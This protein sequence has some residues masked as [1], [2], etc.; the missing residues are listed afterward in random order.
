MVIEVEK[1]NIMGDGYTPVFKKRRELIDILKTKMFN[2]IGYTGVGSE[3]RMVFSPYGDAE[4]IGLFTIMTAVV[5]KTGNP[6]ILHI[7]YTANYDDDSRLEMSCELP[8]DF[9]PEVTAGA[10]FDTLTQR[11]RSNIKVIEK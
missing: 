2:E 5:F 9:D 4:D 7:L 3:H 10:I 11:S 6:D 1:G 8:D